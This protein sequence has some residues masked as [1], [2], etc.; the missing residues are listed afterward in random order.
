[1]TRRPGRRSWRS[2][3]GT[4]PGLAP[5]PW[6]VLHGASLVRWTAV[7]TPATASS[8]REVQL[9]LE[10]LARG[11]GRRRAPP[12]RP[13]PTAAEEAAEQVAEVAAVV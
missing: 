1:M 10:V 9:G 8:K 5:E 6:Q 12:R 7:V 2:A 4:V 13:P 11:A 3:W